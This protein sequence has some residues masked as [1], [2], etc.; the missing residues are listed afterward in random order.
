MATTTVMKSQKK[1]PTIERA[2]RLVSDLK[3]A[4]DFGDA[5]DA[6]LRFI[7]DV[8]CRSDYLA[9]RS[10]GPAVLGDG[11]FAELYIDSLERRGKVPLAFMLFRIAMERRGWT[12]KESSKKLNRG[13][14]QQH[15]LTTE[16]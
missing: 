12:V 2:E 7:A 11:D 4:R 1:N 13:T 8:D 3:E 15:K 14:N 6:I 10:D 9:D 5:K 16:G